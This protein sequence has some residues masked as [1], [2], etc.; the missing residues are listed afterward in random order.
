M[1]QTR[2]ENVEQSNNLSVRELLPIEEPTLGRKTD[3]LRI[4]RNGHK[5]DDSGH[6]SLGAKRA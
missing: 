5:I 4:D 3:H 2:R 1:Q 6:N